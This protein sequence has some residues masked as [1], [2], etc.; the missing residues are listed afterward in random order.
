[1]LR[2]EFPPLVIFLHQLFQP[3]ILQQNHPLLHTGCARGS[4]TFSHMAPKYD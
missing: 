1:V 3:P 2:D 4:P